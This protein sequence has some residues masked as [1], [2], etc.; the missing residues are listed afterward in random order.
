MYFS[1]F[2]GNYCNFWI[3]SEWQLFSYSS[4]VVNFCFFICH[5]VLSFLG[6]S[7]FMNYFA[8]WL[9]YIAKNHTTNFFTKVQVVPIIM[10]QKV[11]NCETRLLIGE[12]SDVSSMLCTLLSYL[13]EDLLK[14][15]SVKRNTIL[16]YK[17]HLSLDPWE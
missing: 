12:Y 15:S 3:V 13:R 1:F 6:F 17:S 14:S 4:G 8:L 2:P 7:I 9:N 5:H 10:H 11:T 16:F